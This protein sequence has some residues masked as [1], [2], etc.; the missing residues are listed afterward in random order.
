MTE[1]QVIRLAIGRMFRIASRPFQLGDAAE[2]ERCRGI[3]L[4]LSETPKDTTPN[5]A[6]DRL[7]GAQGD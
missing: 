2:Y 6:R 3:I 5:Y 4:D 1:R 7:C